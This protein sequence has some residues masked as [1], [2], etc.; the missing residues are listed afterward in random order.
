MS[1]TLY[2]QPG[3]VL[4]LSEIELTGTRASGPGGQHVNKTSS[5]IQLRFF[6][7]ASSALSEDQ[8]SKL[9]AYSDNHISENGMI[10][11]K[12]QDHRSQHRNRAEALARLKGLIKAALRPK[13]KRKQTRPTRGSVRRRLKA[14]AIRGE[15]K[16]FRGKVDRDSLD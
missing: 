5:A 2:I 8:K 10:V 3:L 1:D 14:K 12:A 11:I 4:P 13:Q 7:P 9:F 15:K 6:I 16:A